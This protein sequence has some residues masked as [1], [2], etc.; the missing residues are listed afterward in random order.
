MK[1]LLEIDI[2]ENKLKQLIELLKELASIKDVNLISSN[3]AKVM[4]E[5]I[6]AMEEL[7]LVKAGKLEARNA[8]DLIN[9]L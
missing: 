9:E 2:K 3:K 7:K 8:E 1:V 5:I 6:E 4:K